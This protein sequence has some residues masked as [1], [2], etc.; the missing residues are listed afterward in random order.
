MTAHRPKIMSFREWCHEEKLKC[1]KKLPSCK[2][3]SIM[4]C[5]H[6][7]LCPSCETW[8]SIINPQAKYFS[9]PR[10]FEIRKRLVWQSFSGNLREHAWKKTS[11]NATSSRRLYVRHRQMTRILKITSKV[12][13]YSSPCFYLSLHVGSAILINMGKL[14][15]HLRWHYWMQA[16]QACVACRLNWNIKSRIASAMCASA[17]SM[18]HCS[19]LI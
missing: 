15:W 1:I 4:T 19:L 16:C 13:V 3:A 17:R 18:N 11:L 2:H 9:W 14:G 6:K 7:R 12:K 10:L 5:S 8:G